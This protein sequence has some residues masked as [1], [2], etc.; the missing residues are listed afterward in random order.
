MMDSE[1]TVGKRGERMLNINDVDTFLNDFRNYKLKS[2]EGK[3][4][5]NVKFEVLQTIMNHTNLTTDIIKGYDGCSIN[6]YGDVDGWN[7]DHDQGM[8]MSES[9]DSGI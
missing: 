5:S 7:H 9:V 8:E 4:K 2:I 1:G 6:E 3:Q